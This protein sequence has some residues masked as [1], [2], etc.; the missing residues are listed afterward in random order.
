MALTKTPSCEI[1]K[2]MSSFT[3]MSTSDELIKSDDIVGKN[4]TVI[5]FICNH[6]PYVIAIIK[7]LVLTAKK[8]QTI[9]ISSAAIMPND[10]KNYPDD[11]FE[12]MKVFSDQN[13]FCFP[14]LL[15]DTQE[16]AKNFGAVCTPDF[17]GYDSDL[18]LQYRGRLREL[19]NFVPVKDGESDLL[20]AMKQVAETQNGPE[21]QIPSAGCGI[22]WKYD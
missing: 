16:V 1:D 13:Q 19:K 14:Y 22:K 3:L 21:D 7:E 8:L 2:K 17:F 10:Y 5:M 6:C 15:D 4:G 18:K 20:T 11:C 12:K 9:G